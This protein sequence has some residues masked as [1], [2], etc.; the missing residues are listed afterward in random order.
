VEILPGGIG[1]GWGGS[2]GGE[3]RENCFIVFLNVT[4]PHKIGY[5]PDI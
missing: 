3:T 5:L 4:V 2:C 1:R